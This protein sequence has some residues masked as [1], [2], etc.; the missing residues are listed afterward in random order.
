MEVPISRPARDS[1]PGPARAAPAVFVGHV[2]VLPL[3]PVPLEERLDPSIVDGR[4][5]VHREAHAGHDRRDEELHG[6]RLAHPLEG[7]P[8]PLSES[9]EI[10]RCRSHP[11][12]RPIRAR[13][14]VPWPASSSRCCAG[15]RP[16]LGAAHRAGAWR[17]RDVVAH[18]LDGTLRRVSFHRDRLTA[19]APDPPPRTEREF[20]AFING[21]NARWVEA[22]KRMS[23]R[24]LTDVFEFAGAS[25]ADFV[26]ALPA[27]A[28]AFFPVSW[29]GEGESEGWFDMDASSRS[30]GTTR[31]RFGRGRR[32]AVARPAP[33]CTRCC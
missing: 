18:I 33:G 12:P 23:P 26:E 24:V 9:A 8:I 6:A 29:A 7:C 31:P 27:A 2:E 3:V 32:A 4:R 25:L 17:V 22:A 10:A 15:C 5:G 20:V 14:S 19:P 28:P 1:P 11:C 13:T 16:R 30:C 21:L